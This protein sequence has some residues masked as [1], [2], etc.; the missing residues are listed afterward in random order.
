LSEVSGYRPTDRKF[1]LEFMN[2]MNYT[3][4]MVAKIG[5]RLLPGLVE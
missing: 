5:I 4:D 1:R 3:R 2:F